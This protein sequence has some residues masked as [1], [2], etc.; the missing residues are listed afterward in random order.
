MQIRS[1]AVLE[2]IFTLKGNLA[3]G[4]SPL[5]RIV[6]GVEVAPF[7]NHADA[8]SCISADFEMGWGWRSRGP[9][10]A[11]R[12]GMTERQQVPL[13]LRLLEE[14]S[15]P[16]TWAT[17]GH[18]FLESC[19][20][21]S[22]GLAHPSMPRPATDGTWSGDWYWPDPCSNVQEAPAWYGPDLIQQI[23]ASKVPHEIG[24]H[25]FSHINFQALYSS[26][27]VVLRELESCIDLMRP[28]GL[29]PR[30]LIF[31]RH[32]SEES[33]LPLLASAGVTVIRHRDKRIRL[34]Y[35]ER[36]TSGIYKV[37]ESMNLRIAKHYD[38]LDKVKLFI[39]KAK[40][41]HA[42][43]A[44]WFHPSDPT[45]WFDPQLR[46][47]LEYMAAER[48]R[49]GLWITTMQELAGY[50]EAREQLQLTVERHQGSLTIGIDSSLDT[51]RYGAVDVTLLIP[52]PSKPTSAWL[53]LTN[54]ERRSVDARAISDGSTRV[55]VNVPTTAK[56]LHLTF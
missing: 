56:A 14:Y 7:K 12:M 51:S 9:A 17:I 15:I 1:T 38:Y 16:V 45:E 36:T 23:V 13:I 41:R 44:L 54:A 42:A 33:Y 27:D 48:Q 24:T 25:S 22:A 34:S 11:E 53:V 40:D 37:Y 46:A 26:P 32:Q 49:G 5:R 6:S 8:A 10:G 47:I 50:C 31:P 20:R 21:S 4:D 19:T 28:L 35:P 55:M 39:G 3:Q 29:R 2:A 43:Y 30:T 52:V 18:L